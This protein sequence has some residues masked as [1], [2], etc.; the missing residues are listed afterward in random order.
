MITAGVPRPRAAR[1]PARSYRTLIRCVLA[2]P[3][4]LARRAQVGGQAVIEG[5]MMRGTDNWSLAVRR[6]DETIALHDW[7]LVSWM[8]RYPIL[9][10]PILRGVTA[11]VESLA[12]GVRAISISA[13]ESLGED[14]PDLSKKEIGLTLVV[15]LVLAVGLFFLAPLGLTGL[16]KHWLGTGITFWL[17]EGLVRVTIF[18]LYLLI[19]TRI[20][21]LRRVFEYHGAEHMAIHALEHG[22][23]LTPEA[24]KKYRTLHLRCGTSFLL[25]VMVVSIIVFAI[26]RWPVWYLLILSRVILIPLIAGVSYEIIKLAGRHE[27]NR[28]VRTLMAPGLA[29]QWM[30]TKQPDTA[31]LEVALAAL[32][33][34][35]ELEP[36]DR[37]PVKGVEVMA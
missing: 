1:S 30:T 16:F 29:L 2:A 37:P 18:V 13:N 6:P 23:E 34:I 27:D 25:I 12:I 15:S 10:L 11:L 4:L 21:D 17:V 36:Q 5:V 24:C 20:P 8:V 19:V 22:E 31:Q 3:V 26:V 32:N 35:I 28:V 14:Q 9:K 33:K 7:P